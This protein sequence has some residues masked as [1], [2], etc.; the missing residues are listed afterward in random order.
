MFINFRGAV[1]AGLIWG[2]VAILLALLVAF[3][4]Q[5]QALVPNFAGI[6]L[7]LF[8]VLFAGVHYTARNKGNILEHLI[9]G[10]IAGII[11]GLLLFGVSLVLPQVQ[12]I[13]DLVGTL[14][15]GLIGGALGALG[16]TVVNRV[17]F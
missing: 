17:N 13:G 2:V 7:G 3:V 16:M 8:A 11:A 10:I 6:T 12:P 1:A 9:G 5:I 14:I 15:T 4:P